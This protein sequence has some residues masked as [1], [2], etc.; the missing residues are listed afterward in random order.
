MLILNNWALL[1]LIDFICI[2]CLWITSV[3]FWY[4]F[5][6]PGET[7]SIAEEL[8]AKD[9]LKNMMGSADNRPPLK[10]GEKAHTLKL[11]FDKKNMSVNEVAV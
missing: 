4:C 2:S 11:D 6:A 8:A 7:I 9:A 5:A 10:M 1:S 3:I